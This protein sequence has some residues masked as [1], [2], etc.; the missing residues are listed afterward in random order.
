MEEVD[1]SKRGSYMRSRHGVLP[2]WANE[3]LRD[4]ERIVLTP[5]PASVSGRSDRTIGWSSSVR[6]VITVI[7]LEHRGVVYGVNGWFA[8]QRDRRRYEDGPA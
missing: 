5:D 2:E 6:T 1:W 8:N 3:A 7:T 4:T